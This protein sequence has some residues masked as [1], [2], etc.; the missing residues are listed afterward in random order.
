MWSHS[1]FPKD[2]GLH[3]DLKSDAGSIAGAW[4]SSRGVLES[5]A[6]LEQA[7][8]ALSHPRRAES[9]SCGRGEGIGI[10]PYT[11]KLTPS[12]ATLRICLVLFVGNRLLI[13]FEFKHDIF[14]FPIG[15]TYLETYNIFHGFPN[16]CRYSNPRVKRGSLI[17]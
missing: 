14:V 6:T 8:K 12:L 13:H 10:A 16:T 3:S 1:G 5:M 11:T 7:Q 15:I 2:S 17:R 4:V 9:G